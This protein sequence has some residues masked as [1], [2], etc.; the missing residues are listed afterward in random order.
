MSYKYMSCLRKHSAI[1][2]STSEVAAEDLSE[3]ARSASDLHKQQ[4]VI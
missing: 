1:Q 4:V 2:R 3:M